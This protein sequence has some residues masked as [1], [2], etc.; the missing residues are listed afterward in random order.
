MSSNYERR[1]PSSF[2]RNPS[3]PGRD[4]PR[5]GQPSPVGGSESALSPDEQ[6]KLEQVICQGDA[7][8]IIDW[9]AE[10]GKKLADEKLAT[11]QIRNVY[12][13]VKRIQLSW[14][15]DPTQA[16]RETV[17]LIPKLHYQ[18]ARQDRKPGFQGLKSFERVMVPAL[19]LFSEGK[20]EEE[21]LKRFTNLADFFEAI[22]AYHKKYGGRD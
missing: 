6:R 12:G 21:R 1:G 20:D 18:V 14:A 2:G 10:I 17:L 5:P 11:S 19:K 15:Q 4:A 16:F 7:R 22:L 3:G 8:V 9:S 13:T